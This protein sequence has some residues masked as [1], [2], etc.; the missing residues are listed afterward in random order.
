MKCDGCG[1]ESE[2]EAAFAKERK[3]FSKSTRTLCPMCRG[4]RRRTF[5]GWYQVA[6][7]V[8]GVVGYTIL[9]RYPWSSVGR[10]LT[11]LFL[12]DIFLILSIVPHELGHAIMGR[13]LGWRVFAIVIGIGKRIFKFNLFGM[14]FSFHWLP[15]GGLAQLAPT[16]T[17][18]FRTKRFL[19]YLA[20][21]AVNGAIVG[22]IL[23]IWWD[24]FREWGFYW[25]LPRPARLCLWANFWIMVVN[26]WPH[27]SRVLNADTDG[28]QLLKTFSKKPKDAEEL[29]ALRFALEASLRRDEHKD[30]E[31][32]LDW[33]NRG[34]ALYPQNVALLN[35]SGILCLDKQ[36]YTRAREIFLQLLNSEMN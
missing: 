15:V 24:S 7:M 19:V 11:I 10:F 34:L 2:F 28:M 3:S 8:G 16:D 31:G 1:T 14:I 17:R 20:G 21:P 12:M 22:I 35:L 9:W 23:C 5:E 25:G 6:V 32:A 13:L 30:M 26:L 4:R 33:C 27:R 36:D 18:W 29:Q